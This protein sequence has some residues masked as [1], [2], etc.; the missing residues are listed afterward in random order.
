MLFLARQQS[1]KP[2][3]RL[4]LNLVGAPLGALSP[5]LFHDDYP[6]AVKYAGFGYALTDS[7]LR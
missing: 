5:L 1:S 3:H 4:Q 6:A 2:V 7:V